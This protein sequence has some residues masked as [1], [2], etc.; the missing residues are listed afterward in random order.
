MKLKIILK[1]WKDFQSE[2][3]REKEHER[4][5]RLQNAEQLLKHKKKK[6]E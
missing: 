3:M 5:I 1:T 4:L 6:D 2:K